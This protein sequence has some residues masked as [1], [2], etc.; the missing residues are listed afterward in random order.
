M[1]MWTS[2]SVSWTSLAL[3]WRGS[4]CNALNQRDSGSPQIAAVKSK[5]SSST[6]FYDGLLLVIKRGM[7]GGLRC[8]AL[9]AA[10]QLKETPLDDRFSIEKIWKGTN[11]AMVVRM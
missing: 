7:Q 5:R 8:A 3:A 10:P 2:V 6:V 1:K 11:V 4:E 9:T